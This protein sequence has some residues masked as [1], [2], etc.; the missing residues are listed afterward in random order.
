MHA[1]SH[2]IRFSDVLAGAGNRLLHAAA[3]YLR[4]WQNRRQVA[5]LLEADDRM[6]RDI[7]LTRGDVVG[8]LAGPH[9]ADPSHHLIRARGEKL[10][11]REQRRLGC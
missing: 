3:D 9:D 11:A 10:R 6:L 8:A 7:G 2:S 4:T 5:N 1:R